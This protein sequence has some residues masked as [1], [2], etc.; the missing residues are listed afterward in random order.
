MTWTD[1]TAFVKKHKRNQKELVK[2]QCCVCAI[3][4]VRKETRI[5]EEG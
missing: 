2:G 4:E 1:K 5:E 3:L